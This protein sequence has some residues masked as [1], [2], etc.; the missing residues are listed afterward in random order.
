MVQPYISYM[1]VQLG[2]C[3]LRARHLRLQ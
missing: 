1:T 2:A 3:A